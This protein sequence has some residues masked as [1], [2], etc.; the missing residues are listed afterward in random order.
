MHFA[1]TLC[2]KID[3]KRVQHIQCDDVYF[4][5]DLWKEE[6]NTGNDISMYV[7]MRDMH[8]R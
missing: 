4:G 7:Y 8:K 5:Q 3:F 2:R 6:H 1:Q